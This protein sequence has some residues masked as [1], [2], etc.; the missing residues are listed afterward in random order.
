MNQLDQVTFSDSKKLKG[1]ALRQ[2]K[3]TVTLNAIQKEIIVVTLLG[4]ASMPLRKGNP[5][6]SVQFV[7]TRARSDYIWHLYDILKNFVGTPSRVQ[8]LRGGQALALN[9][10]STRFQTYSHPEFKFYYDLFYPAH[11]KFYGRP[12][13]TSASKYSPIIDCESTRLLVYG[14]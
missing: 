3:K 8:N 9:Y 13:K 1:N 10:E 5:L 14:R 2:Y 11:Y 12:E 4:D 7:Q 6:W